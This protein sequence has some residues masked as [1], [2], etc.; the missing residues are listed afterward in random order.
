VISN[1]SDSLLATGCYFLPGYHE[2]CG[3]LSAARHQLSKS[4][5]RPK[6]YLGVDCGLHNI[7]VVQGEN[8]NHG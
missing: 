2:R 8:Y 7:Y 5:V 4:G 1:Q 3:L 6:A